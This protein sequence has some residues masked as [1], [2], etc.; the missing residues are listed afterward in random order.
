MTGIADKAFAER[1]TTVSVRVW[2]VRGRFVVTGAFVVFAVVSD[3][4]VPI[5][6]RDVRWEIGSDGD[7]GEL[8]VFCSV[9]VVAVIF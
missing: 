5:D 9:L 2:G 1:I 7:E 8:V 3:S 4:T 6:D